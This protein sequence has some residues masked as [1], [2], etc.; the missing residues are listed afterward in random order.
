M[1]DLNLLWVQTKDILE[2][3]DCKGKLTEHESE[4]YCNRMELM[5][6]IETIQ[7]YQND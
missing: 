1:I 4:V 6:A 5:K 3:L 7:R 2:E